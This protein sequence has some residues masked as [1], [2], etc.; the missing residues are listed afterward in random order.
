MSGQT[1]GFSVQASRWIGRVEAKYGLRPG[2]NT[3]RPASSRRAAGEPSAAPQSGERGMALIAVMLVMSLMVMLALA[4]TFTALSDHSI[5]ANF[6]NGASGFYA[7]EAGMNNVHRL[8]HGD[9]IALKAIPNPPHVTPGQPTL[10]PEGIAAA[11]GQLLTISEHFPND[12]A[13]HTKLKITDINVPYPAAD[14]NPGHGNR[15]FYNDPLNPAMGQTENYIIGYQVD[16]VGEGIA[17]LNGTVTLEEQGVL[18]FSLIASATSGGARRGNFAEF[19]LFTDRFDPYHPAGPFIYQGLGPGDNFSGKVHTNQTFGFWTGADGQD[20]P[21]FKG[22]VSQSSQTASYYRYGAGDPPPPVDANSEVVGGVLVAPQFMAGFDRGV[23][24]VPP[25]SNAFNQAQAVLDGGFSLS[26]NPPTD[27]QLHSILRDASQLTTALGDPKDPASTTPDMSPGIYIPTDGEIF[28]GS[29]IYVMGSA[30]QILLKADPSG[31]RQTITITQGGNT[32]TV[33]VDVDAGTTTIDAGSGPHT[34]RG[35]PQDRTSQTNRPGASLYVYGDVKSLTGPGRDAS[36]QPVAAIDSSFALTVTAAAYLT[37]DSGRQVAGGNVT[38]TG[39]LT[40]ETPVVDSVGNPINPKAQNVLG[41]YA[42]GGNVEVPVDGR[43]P[44][45]LQVNASLAAFEMRDAQGNPVVNAFGG[46]IGGRVRSDLSNWGDVGN[47]GRFTLVGGMQSTTY[48][49]FAVYNGSIHGYSYQGFWDPR[50]D[51]TQFS[52]P[53]YPGYVVDM[54][55][56]TDTP[57]IS[58]QSN[59]PT[60]LSYK[61]IYYGTLPPGSPPSGK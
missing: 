17:G 22:H 52:P 30:D 5:T 43:A 14:Q 10:T 32:V 61:R 27:A 1:R 37:G 36:G 7:A 35:I 57:V 6:R 12:A 49:N 23:P 34:L 31:N 59:K 21:V 56:P 39:D 8:L 19:A 50:Y 9:Q 33:V 40:Y 15:V 41:I 18:T 16:S 28:T 58:V 24:A 48:D 4:V 60:V 47:M 2:I 29:G 38:I 25:P 46:P 11:A 53:F 20:A 13:Y 54:G 44:T 55:T 45:N 26:A 51:T 3:G 42:S